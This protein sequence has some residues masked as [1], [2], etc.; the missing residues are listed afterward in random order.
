MTA[1]RVA[2]LTAPASEEAI[3]AEGIIPNHLH[4]WELEIDMDGGF[5]CICLFGWKI[6]PGPRGK[7]PRDRAC[8][9]RM[10]QEE[11][12]DALREREALTV[13]SGPLSSEKWAFARR[14]VKIAALLIA[15][16]VIAP[17]PAHAQEFNVGAAPIHGGY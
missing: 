3:F 14:N 2:E 1:R 11:V 6:P 5:D 12:Q 16:F 17:L 10:T 7:H 8:Y 9:A 4:E 15:L 13:I